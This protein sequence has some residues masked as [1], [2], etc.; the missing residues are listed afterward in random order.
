MIFLAR[1]DIKMPLGKMAAQVA[2]A[3]L[4]AFKQIEAKS[5]TD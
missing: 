4:A 2:S 1:M 5:D 3:A